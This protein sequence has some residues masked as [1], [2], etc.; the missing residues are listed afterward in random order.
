MDH[1]RRKTKGHKYKAIRP[2]CEQGKGIGLAW[3]PTEVAAKISDEFQAEEN[4]SFDEDFE[5]SLVSENPD[6]STVEFIHDGQT[7]FQQIFPVFNR[8]L[9]LID[10]EDS[11]K[12]NDELETIPPPSEAQYIARGGAVQQPQTR[13]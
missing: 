10:D 11:K 5:F 8:G 1:S 13:L 12:V 4:D 6:I 3:G 2:K 7:K 9:L